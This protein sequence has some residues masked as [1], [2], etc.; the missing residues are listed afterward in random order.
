MF[1][2]TEAV[3]IRFFIFELEFKRGFVKAAASPLVELF[4]YESVRSE[5]FDCIY[6]IHCEKERKK[7]HQKK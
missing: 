7:T 2:K 5:S 4:A 1:L 3:N 6:M